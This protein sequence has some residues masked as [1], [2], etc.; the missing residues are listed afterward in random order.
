VSGNAGLDSADLLV[1]AGCS[2]VGSGSEAEAGRNGRGESRSE[3]HFCEE[4]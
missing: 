4:V 2:G 3:A 1:V